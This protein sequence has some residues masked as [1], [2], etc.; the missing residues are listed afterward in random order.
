[1]LLYAE[2]ITLLNDNDND[3]DN[4]DDDDNDNCDG[5]DDANTMEIFN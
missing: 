1:M 3:N 4:D 5:N 2:I